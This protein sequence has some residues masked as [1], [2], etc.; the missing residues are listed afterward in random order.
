M[1]T[2]LLGGLWHGAEWNFVLWGA[3]QGILLCILRP[4]ENY[5]NIMANNKSLFLRRILSIFIMFNFTWI[6]WIFFR[7]NS[8]SDAYYAIT[9]LF[10]DLS[11]NIISLNLKGGILGFYYIIGIILF[12]EFVHV[13]QEHVKMRH[14]LSEKPLWLRWPLYLFIIFLIL[15]FGVFRSTQFIYF[16]F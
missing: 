10:T 7:A 9:H 16:Q 3:Y 12:M 11:F 15:L 8:L 1:I 6:G 2:M 14:F 5:F 13:I 4:F